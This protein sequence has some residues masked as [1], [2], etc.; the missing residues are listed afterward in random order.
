MAAEWIKKPKYRV[1]P[2]KN[3]LCI[4]GSIS[5]SKWLQINVEVKLKLKSHFSLGHHVW[6]HHPLH[7]CQSLCLLWATFGSEPTRSQQ[8]IEGLGITRP[9]CQQFQMIGMNL[10]E[11]FFFN[12]Y[13]ESVLCWFRSE[14]MPFSDLETNRAWTVNSKIAFTTIWMLMYRYSQSTCIFASLNSDVVSLLPLS[15]RY[16]HIRWLT[17]FRL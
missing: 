2:P 3:V 12:V 13:I 6:W 17:V 14:S 9:E 4:C 11:F 7:L 15:G 8:Q 1:P 16:R 10:I 5:G